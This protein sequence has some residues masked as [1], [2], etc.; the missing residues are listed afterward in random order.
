[1]IIKGAELRNSPFHYTFKVMQ[2]NNYKVSSQMLANISVGSPDLLG[3]QSY[4]A[5]CYAKNIFLRTPSLESLFQV[6]KG[7]NTLRSLFSCAILKD[8]YKLS[9]LP[10]CY[11][12]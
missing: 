9:I 4:F 12:N 3:K 1:M 8:A 7:K 6:E 10:S 2:K 11:R 5:T